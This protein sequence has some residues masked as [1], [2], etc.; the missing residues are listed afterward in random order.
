MHYNVLIDFYYNGPSLDDICTKYGLESRAS[1]S[2]L[3]HRARYRVRNAFRRLFQNQDK[4]AYAQV[5]RGKR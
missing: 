1:V 3:L 5:K 2:G 4:G